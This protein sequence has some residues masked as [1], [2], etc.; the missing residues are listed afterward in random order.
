MSSTNQKIYSNAHTNFFEKIVL[1]KR[2]EITNVIKNFLEDKN[3]ENILDIGST[4]DD[5][6]TSSN[7]IVKNLGKY[8]EYKSISDQSLEI[9]FFNRILKK[10]ITEDFSDEEITNF[11][12][13]N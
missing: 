8:K 2:L 1:K 7:F 11:K 9:G 12:C 4:S 6:N 10:S 5:I 13:N 3:I